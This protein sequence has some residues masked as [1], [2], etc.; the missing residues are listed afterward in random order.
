MKHAF[1]FLLLQPFAIDFTDNYLHK[2]QKYLIK[3]KAKQQNCKDWSRWRQRFTLGVLNA[4]KAFSYRRNTQVSTQS[5]RQCTDQTPRSYQ[6]VLMLKSDALARCED[7]SFSIPTACW[8]N[9]SLGAWR[10]ATNAAGDCDP[11]KQRSHTQRL[12]WLQIS[13]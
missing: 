10:S 7:R 12:F 2:Q 13:Q 11:L 3:K 9:D 8:K 4:E 5:S 6:L 1:V